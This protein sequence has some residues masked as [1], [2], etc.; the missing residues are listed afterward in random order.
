MKLI[1]L[2]LCI[3]AQKPFHTEGF[4]YEVKED[5]HRIA[6]YKDGS[7]LQ[8][9]ARSGM[10]RTERYKKLIEPFRKLPASQAVLDCEAVGYDE[11]GV[12]HINLVG[13]NTKL[14]LFDIPIFDRDLRQEPLRVRREFLEDATNHIQGEF[15]LVE[16]LSPNG[17][18]ASK[19]ALKRGCEGIIAKDEQSFY[20]GTR[21]SRWIKWKVSQQKEFTVV[22]YQESPNRV[23]F[24]SLLLVNSDGVYV[25]RVGTGFTQQDLDSISSNFKPSRST[26][27]RD[28]S[29]SSFLGL[30]IMVKPFSVKVAYQEIGSG[31]HLRF[32]VFL[33]VV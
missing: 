3:M 31:G 15:S 8:V 24:A 23:G 25:G 14:V 19:I 16:R 22:G 33:N 27:V 21:Y 6:I 13:K 20:T 7:D 10:N 12:S 11:N 1:P 28:S 18:E 9:I 30:G 2:T 32:P 26:M 29:G 4:C 17:I 5:G